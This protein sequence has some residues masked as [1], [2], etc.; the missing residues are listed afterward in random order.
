MSDHSR[1]TADDF[2]DIPFADVPAPPVLEGETRRSFPLT[3]LGNA[4]RLVAEHGRDLR[5]SAGLGWFAWDGRC[6]RR[7]SDGEALRRAKRTVRAMY[8]EAIDLDDP[9]ARKAQSAW[10]IKSES[11]ARLRASVS[12]AESERP[13][14]VRPDE[15]DA[16]PLLFNALNGTVD[17]RTGELREHRREDLLTKMSGAVYDPEARSELWERVLERATRHCAGLAGFVQRAAGYSMTG[18]TVEEVL[19]FLHG[20]TA[21][22]KSTVAEALKAAFGEYATTADFETFL[23][24]RGAAGIRN[25]I[26]RLWSAH[27]VFS[28]EVSDG[29]AL[30]EGLLKLLTGGDTVAARFLYQETF[31]FMP[32]F[33]LWL[34]A[35]ERPRVRAED[36]AMWRR[37]LQ[38]PFTEEIP[39]EERDERV[40]IELR[41]NPEVRAAILAW[42][43]RGCLEWQGEGLGVPDCVREYTD[44]YRAENDPLR[45]WLADACLLCADCQTASSA[46]RASYESWCETNGEK[47]LSTKA[48]GDGLRGRRLKATKRGGRRVWEGIALRD[49]L[50]LPGEPV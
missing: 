23:K 46:L 31:E 42:A 34:A 16:D 35:N 49:E 29:A 41:T 26:A 40:K 3:D 10:A 18:Y 21:T 1:V 22:A 13:V 32:R 50:R 27:I 38:V 4:E 6:W 14:I 25:D 7:D 5:Y 15:F 48:Y 43:V 20:P 12:L 45:D 44:E 39:V 8:A 11:A 24:R 17:L 47:P 33:T 2:Y 37:I 28:I 19:L 30:A 36:S 9:D